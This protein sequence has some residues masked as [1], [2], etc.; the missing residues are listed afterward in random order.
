MTAPVPF[1][2]GS[3][4]IDTAPRIAE[5]GVAGRLKRP[6]HRLAKHMGERADLG[7][8]GQTSTPDLADG[9]PAAVR[10]ALRRV[11]VCR[12]GRMHLRFRAGGTSISWAFP[13]SGHLPRLRHAEQRDRTRALTRAFTQPPEIAE[14]RDVLTWPREAPDAWP[15]GR[16]P[17]SFAWHEIR[18]WNGVEHTIHGL[19]GRV[20]VG[21]GDRTNPCPRL[22]GAITGTRWQWL[23]A[24]SGCRE[25]KRGND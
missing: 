3:L 8:E 25:R 10:H 15:Q 22:R 21:R 11:G 4:Q 9:A 14:T 19:A 2:G 20:R 18:E 13:G 17:M 1:E 5:S 16:R 24:S 23:L 12:D 7:D 6:P